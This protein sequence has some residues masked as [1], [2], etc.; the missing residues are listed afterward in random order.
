MKKYLLLL[1]FTFWLSAASA[2]KRIA[3]SIRPLLAQNM[4]DTARVILLWNLSAAYYSFMPDSSLI[5]GEEALFLAQKIK[6]TAGEAK[7]LAKIANASLQLGNYTTALE[8]YLR[9][10]KLE[11]KRDNPARMASVIQNI[12]IVYLYQEEYSKALSYY[13]RADSIMKTIQANDAAADFELRYQ[14]ANNIGDLYYRINR[15]DSA[16]IYFQEALAIAARNQNTNYMGTSLLGLGEVSLK[17]R[18]FVQ[19]KIQFNTAI[20]YLTE[21]NNEDL[22]CETFLGM[23]N[24]Y[25][26]LGRQEYYAQ[27]MMAF[28]VKDG[29]L[30][31]QLK[32]SIFLNSYYKKW[33]NIDSAYIYLE[34]SQQL[35]DS[36]NS[37]KKVRELQAISSNEQLRQTEI[38]EQ[39]RIARKERMEQLQLLGIGIFIPLFFLT[40]LIISRRKVHVSLL[41]FF[42]VISLLI[43]FEY[44]TLLLHP[45]VADITHH[46]PIYELLIF[47]CIAAVLIRAHHRIEAWFI[48][49]LI[50]SKKRFADGYIPTKRIRIKMKKPPEDLS[51]D[52]Q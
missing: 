12:G 25:D 35:N 31:W 9:W 40:I 2:Q 19:A 34:L 6:Y 27:K 32:A 8:Y 13:Y 3:D 33:R 1:S 43:L 47:V 14:I 48:D 44:L 36:I 7:S 49:K 30:Q 51:T 39:K 52:G 17:K 42:G 22:L 23:A 21:V 50:Q 16:F 28:A 18:D 29:F 4:H 45:Y 41:R 10:L 11:E 37:N 24:L 26:S 38:A 15:L 20:N 46:T 5:I